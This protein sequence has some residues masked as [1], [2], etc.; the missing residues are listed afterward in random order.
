MSVQPARRE[1]IL[2]AMQQHGGRTKLLAPLQEPAAD[3]GLIRAGESENAP[4]DEW[5]R[6]VPCAFQPG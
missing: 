6:E 3:R 4:D 2:M 1:P 5:N